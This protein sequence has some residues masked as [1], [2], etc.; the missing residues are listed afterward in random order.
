L[1]NFYILNIF[2]IFNIFSWPGKNF[3][4]FCPPPLP[5]AKTDDSS[6]RGTE[7]AMTGADYDLMLHC[8]IGHM[9][10]IDGLEPAFDDGEKTMNL[11]APRGTPR[12][13]F[14]IF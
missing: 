6:D 1:H 10:R 9:R 8:T 3:K 7:G 12:Y 13:I 14:C 11:L 4:Y 2:N 5:K